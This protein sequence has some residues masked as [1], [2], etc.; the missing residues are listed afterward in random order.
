MFRFKS[1][2]NDFTRRKRIDLEPYLN[3]KTTKA[4]RMYGAIL[5]GKEAM[6]TGDK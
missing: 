6:D 4:T 1:C 3:V 2:M 5:N